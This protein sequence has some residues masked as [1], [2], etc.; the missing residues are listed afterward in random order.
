MGMGM[1]LVEAILGNVSED[2]RLCDLQ[3]Q[4]QARGRTETVDLT[5]AEAQ[6]GRLR[7]VTDRD[8]PIG[9]SLG[10]GSI[11]RDG[12]VLYLNEPEGRMIVARLKP[13]EVLRITVKP[14]GSPAD[15]LRVAVQLGHMLGNQHWPVKIEGMTVY[16]PVSV[17]T[18]VM[19]TVL[20]TYNL[21]GIEYRFEQGNVGAISR[22]VPHEHP[23]PSRHQ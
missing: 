15:L 1:I 7:T 9:I 6:K 17:D 11:V 4:W 13:E 14:A 16:V 5:P 12:D 21:D 20:R 19:D 10:R 22:V 23:H 8:T 3:R 2:A 18:K